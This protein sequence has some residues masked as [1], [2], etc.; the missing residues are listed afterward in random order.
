MKKKENIVI[1]G[2]IRQEIDKKRRKKGDERVSSCGKRNMENNKK[3]WTNRKLR[4]EEK[5]RHCE[6]DKDRRRNKYI[7]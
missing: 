6:L 5:G 3:E 4:R 1:G 2:Q 7:S